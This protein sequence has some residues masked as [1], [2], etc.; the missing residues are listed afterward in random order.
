MLIWSNWFFVNLGLRVILTTSSE[1]GEMVT[2]LGVPKE[3]K[4]LFADHSLSWWH[5]Y[6]NVP[7]SL[8]ATCLNVQSGRYMHC[9]FACSWRQSLLHTFSS[10]TQIHFGDYQWGKIKED[11]RLVFLEIRPRLLRIIVGG[12]WTYRRLCKFHETLEIHLFHFSQT[13][14]QCFFF[15]SNLSSLS[16]FWFHLTITLL[17]L[18][19]NS[20]CCFWRFEQSL[21][22]DFTVVAKLLL[23]IEKVKKKYQWETSWRH[24]SE[25]SH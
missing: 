16:L 14:L 11:Q 21:L 22:I 10:R 7:L 6:L 18:K 2:K 9:C 25:W 15:L 3:W 8:T 24:M 20:F 5:I 4:G 1:W 12:T 13:F 19:L 23:C 17:I